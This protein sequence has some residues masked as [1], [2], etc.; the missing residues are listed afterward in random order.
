MGLPQMN[1]EFALYARKGP[2][3]FLETKALPPVVQHHDP[4][5][6]ASPRSSMPWSGALRQANVWICLRDERYKDAMVG[7]VKPQRRPKA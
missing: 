5:I 2:A 6:T 1:T 4:T 3:L 7:D